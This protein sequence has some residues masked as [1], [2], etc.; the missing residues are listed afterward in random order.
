MTNHSEP[1]WDERT[2]KWHERVRDELKLTRAADLTMLEVA[3]HAM[4]RSHG[5]RTP[6]PDDLRLIL[7]ALAA[8]T[9]RRRRWFW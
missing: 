8:L 3:S 9:S 1:I 7:D 2:D 6:H 4:H 5:S